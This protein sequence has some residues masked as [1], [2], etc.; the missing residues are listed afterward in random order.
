MYEQRSQRVMFRYKF[1]RKR[2]EIRLNKI[3]F[4]LAMGD[5]VDIF[6]IKAVLLK[7]ILVKQIFVL[8]MEHSQEVHIPDILS[9]D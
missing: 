9:C 1:N 2:L 5:L 3:K 8:D 7:K 6:Y 4:M